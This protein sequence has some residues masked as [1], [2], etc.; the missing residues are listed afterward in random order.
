MGRSWHQQQLVDQDCQGPFYQTGQSYLDQEQARLQQR[1]E[2]LQQED[3]PVLTTRA[4]AAAGSGRMGRKQ[5]EP[6]AVWGY[7]S[8]DGLEADDVSDILNHLD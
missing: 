3:G 6:A 2:Q 5:Q 1:I 7:S 4:S 8:S